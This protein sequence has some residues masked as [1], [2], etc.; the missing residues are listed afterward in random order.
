MTD[1]TA[2]HFLSDHFHPAG[3]S[4]IDFSVIQ[5]SHRCKKNDLIKRSDLLNASSVF[6]IN[7]N[8]SAVFY[9]KLFQTVKETVSVTGINTSTEQ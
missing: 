2:I 4:F 3:S 5:D 1:A 7:R 9:D 6:L 8:E